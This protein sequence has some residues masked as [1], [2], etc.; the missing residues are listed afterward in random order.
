MWRVV[1]ILS[2]LPV[3]G[4]SWISSGSFGPSTAWA[5]GFPYTESLAAQIHQTMVC[6]D[7]WSLEELF[8]HLGAL[9]C[10]RKRFFRFLEAVVHPLSRRGDEQ[11][12]L[13][14]RLNAILAHDGYHLQIADHESGYPVYR[15]T[16]VNRGVT[17]T[18]KNLIFASVGPKPEIGFRD[19]INNDILI[20]SN[21]ASC[22]VYDRPIHRDGL[23]WR[24]LV[25]WW[26][27]AH[28]P[29]TMS[30]D[31]ARRNLGRRLQTALASDCGATIRC[32]G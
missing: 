31:D 2:T 17:G 19:A 3:I 27:E 24:D 15:T 21:A 25:S 28:C 32:A 7:D 6:N 22:L 5:T 13:V 4:N 14:D 1:L 16:G 29:P 10:T 8:K 23:F 26:R 18:P 11:V 20:L 9:T 30:E 12:Q